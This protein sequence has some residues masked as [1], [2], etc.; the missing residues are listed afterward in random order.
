MR[1]SSWR[2][3]ASFSGNCRLAVCH[4]GVDVSRSPSLTLVSTCDTWRPLICFWSQTA[5]SDLVS[6]GTNSSRAPSFRRMSGLKSDAVS[7][8]LIDDLM[9]VVVAEV[10][11]SWWA[12]SLT[13]VSTTSTERSSEE[14]S[15]PAVWWSKGACRA[16]SPSLLNSIVW[17]TDRDS[18]C[19]NDIFAVSSK[20][21]AVE[22]PSAKVL[23]NTSVTWSA[24]PSPCT[25]LAGK[26]ILTGLID[27]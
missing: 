14:A 21:L 19:D 20:S 6:P 10:A 15:M 2:M 13:N 16:K 4:N 27:S 8:E 25:V 11:W 1:T 3:V 23:V 24:F 5:L 22:S 17:L 9:V 26:D 7:S 12:T 18:V